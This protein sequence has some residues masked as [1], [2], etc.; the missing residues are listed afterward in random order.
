METQLIH[1]ST[2]DNDKDEEA[3]NNLSSKLNLNKIVATLLVTRGIKTIEQAKKFLYPS[4]SNLKDPFSLKDMQKAVERLYTAIKNNEKILIFGDFDADGI[5]ST[6]LLVDFFNY[7]D[8]DVSWYVPHRIKEGYGMQK[9]HIDFA[10]KQNI[11][12]IVTVDCGSSNHEAVNSAR[13]EDI[14][15]IITDH[16][17]IAD[18]MPICTAIINP[19]RDDCSSGLSHLAGVGVAFY[20]LMALR[21]FLRTNNFWTQIDEPNLLDYCDLVA[22]GTIGDMVPLKDE[23]RT[24]SIHGL[25]VIQ[26]GKRIGLKTL[27]DVSRIRL[28]HLDSDDIGFR[29]IPR[30]NAAG[31]LSHAR[32]C[33][34]H[35]TSKEIVSSVKTSALLDD[36]NQKRQ[37]IEHEIVNDIE[38]K[39][40]KNKK[41]L[42]KKILILWDKNWNSS[43]L[44]IAASRLVRK[45]S[46][47]VILISA[48][49][50]PYVGSCRSTTSIDIHDVLSKHAHLLEK[51]GGHSM[52]AGVTIKNDNIEKFANDMEDYMGKNFKKAD[53][54]KSIKIDLAISLDQITFKLAKEISMLRPFGTDNPEPVFLCE[55]VKVVSS[56]IIGTNHR[57]MILSN[58]NKKIGNNNNYDKSGIEALQFNVQDTENL[59][60]FYKKIIFKIKENKFKKNSPQIIVEDL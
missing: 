44:G 29:L 34:N 58:A 38:K 43:V 18:P 51:F 41:L 57:K 26:K 30:I 13:A 4:L 36:L 5:T 60:L 40:D 45:Y 10:V 50:D 11:D 12:L 17:E 35:L 1:K 59:P 37:K 46:K 14:D 42:S 31:R 22:L 49:S 15:V 2:G 27:S 6:S 53:F 19:K 54:K 48:L 24:L 25:K 32:I 7:I 47:P 9:I 33:V 8:A 16:H 52:A 56:I 21:K 23:N 39:I 55:N 28:E 3:I 20:L